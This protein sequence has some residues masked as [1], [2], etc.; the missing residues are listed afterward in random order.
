[1]A[2]LV[3]GMLLQDAILAVL[4]DGVVIALGKEEQDE[5]EE[6]NHQDGNDE[7]NLENVDEDVRED[8][9]LL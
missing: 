8:W 1:M 7:D 9:V 4:V 2:I 6:G 3:N 5:D